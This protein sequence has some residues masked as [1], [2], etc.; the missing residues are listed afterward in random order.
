M[1][2]AI[3]L[4]IQMIVEQVEEVRAIEYL[5]AI[6]PD[7]DS[8]YE[9]IRACIGLATHVC[10]PRLKLIWK[11]NNISTATKIKLFSITLDALAI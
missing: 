7:G 9:E 8:S 2:V 3:Q 4:Y 11:T 1:F 5:G 6:L 10:M